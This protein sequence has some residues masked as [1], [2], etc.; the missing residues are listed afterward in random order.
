MELDNAVRKLNRIERDT[1]LITIG[2]TLL[3]GTL[4]RSLAATAA[5]FLGGIL[6]LAN[7]HF[8]W[9]F[10]KRVFGTETR[11]K[12]AYLVG[13]FFLFF[14]FLGIVVVALLVWKVPLVPFFLGTLALIL[15][16]MLNGILFV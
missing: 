3:T 4:T 2:G 13:V 11:N 9:R 14:L 12:A 5:F 6:M 8:L 16:I 10:T 1:L 15:S 7:F